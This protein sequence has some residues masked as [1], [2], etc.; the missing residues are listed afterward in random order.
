[1]TTSKF[2]IRKRGTGNGRALKAAATVA[3]AAVT[4]TKDRRVSQPR[5]W[6]L[7]NLIHSRRKIEALKKLSISSPELLNRVEL[8]SVLSVSSKKNLCFWLRC[9]HT[10]NVDYLIGISF[11]SL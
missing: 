2:G 4:L 7:K 6:F 9:D 3:P 8:L 1:M 11:Q 10:K 5:P